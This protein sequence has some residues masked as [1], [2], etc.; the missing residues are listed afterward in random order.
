MFVVVRYRAYCWRK[1]TLRGTFFL[2]VAIFCTSRAN[3]ELVQNGDFEAGNVGFQSDYMN[4]GITVNGG[5][6]LVSDPANHYSGAFSY[7]DQTSGT[8]L[9]MAVNAAPVPDVTVWRQVIT[10]PQFSDLEFSIWLSSWLVPEAPAQVDVLF[11]GQSLFKT[12]APNVGAVWQ[13]HSATWNS[14]ANETVDMRIVERNADAFGNDF[15]IDEIS[16]VVVPEPSRLLVLVVEFA[17]LVRLHGR[18]SCRLA[19]QGI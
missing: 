6:E 17:L 18:R 15:A 14:G 13:R 3:A 1:R 16:L 7:G 11:N 4:P 19:Y 8:G 9:M 12:A 2:L 10:V 5:Y